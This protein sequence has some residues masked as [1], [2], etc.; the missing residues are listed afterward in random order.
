MKSPPPIRGRTDAAHQPGNQASLP[1]VITKGGADSRFGKPEKLAQLE[2][3]E[4]WFKDDW[5][6]FCRKVKD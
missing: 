4:R 5:K 3:V 2:A 1:T 6:R